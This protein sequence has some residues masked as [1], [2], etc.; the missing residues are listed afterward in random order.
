M[1]SS[2]LFLTCAAFH[3]HI[4]FVLPHALCS[5][6]H[7]NALDFLFFAFLSQA[8]SGPPFPDNI[9][10]TAEQ[11]FKQRRGRCK[12]GLQPVRFPT[13]IAS[14]R[15]LLKTTLPSPCFGK[16][17]ARSSLL[18]GK[19]RLDHDQSQNLLSYQSLLFLCSPNVPYQ[20]LRSK[21]RRWRVTKRM[22]KMQTVEDVSKHG[23]EYD[24]SH[25]SACE[26]RMVPSKLSTHF[27]KH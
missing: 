14:F 8:A 9:C 11:F 26:S 2:V 13:K 15:H 12:I 6:G 5:S 16:R 23:L 21:E 24:W 20:V 22:Q 27:E 10:R 18:K 19:I 1:S 3:L 7:R 4:V 17:C 25:I